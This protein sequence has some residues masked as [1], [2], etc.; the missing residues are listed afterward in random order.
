[1]KPRRSSRKKF[2]KYKTPGIR[3][4]CVRR[5][6]TDFFTR[7]KKKIHFL[8][9]LLFHPLFFVVFIFFCKQHTNTTV[10]CLNLLRFL[11]DFLFDFVVVVGVSSKEAVQ[12]LNEKL[13]LI[14]NC[15]HTDTQTY[16]H[17]SISFLFVGQTDGADTHVDTHRHKQFFTNEK[18]GN[19]SLRHLGLFVWIEYYEE[20]TITNINKQ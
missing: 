13:F 19:I 7:N 8:S 9:S 14:A 15:W 5:C 6:V 16:T 12:E 4:L 11:W 1:M 18:E 3:L 20:N 10:H 17:T 2:A